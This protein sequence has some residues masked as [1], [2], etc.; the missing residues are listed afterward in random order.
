MV[1]VDN[2]SRE[3]AFD[4]YCTEC[5]YFKTKETDEPCNEC[6]EH[7]SNEGTSKPV[8]FKLMEG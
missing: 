5:K 4:K 6:L 1:E 8:N 3:V 2:N 7:P